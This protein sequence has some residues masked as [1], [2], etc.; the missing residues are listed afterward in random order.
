MIAAEEGEAWRTVA[1]RRLA[2]EILSAAEGGQPC[3]L[4]NRRGGAVA[5]LRETAAN[6]FPCWIHVIQGHVDI[7]PQQALAALASPGATS[8][9]HARLIELIAGEDLC[10]TVVVVQVESDALAQWITFAGTFASARRAYSG[11]AAGLVLLTCETCEPPGG[12]R[13]FDDD[14]IVDPLD[15]LIFVRDRTGWPRGRLAEAATAVLVEACRGNMD[16]I[17]QFLDLDPQQAFNPLAVLRGFPSSEHPRPLRWRDRDEACPL[18]LARQDESLVAQRIWRGQLSVLFPWLEE[19]RGEI[20]TKA[21]ARLAG[22]EQRD[23]LTG[24]VLAMVDYEFGDIAYALKRKGE[25]QHLVNSAHELRITRNK[26]AHCIPL[27]VSD[28]AAAELA[29]RGLLHALVP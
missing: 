25:P 15:A 23:R 27:E 4:R 11:Q 12:C 13:Q 24:D 20:V 19:V 26:L 28:L 6:D 18:W 14:L 22:V 29:A 16:L 10:E 2:H 21:A 5:T 3:I 8:A 17:L 1:G 9:A 7:A